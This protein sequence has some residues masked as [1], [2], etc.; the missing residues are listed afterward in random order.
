MLLMFLFKGGVKVL[1]GT[2]FLLRECQFIFNWFKNIIRYVPVNSLIS[3]PNM[4]LKDS[5]ISRFLIEELS[6]AASR[7]ASPGS[8]P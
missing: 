2:G 4:K 3:G 5:K 6:S 1:F 8:A 7:G